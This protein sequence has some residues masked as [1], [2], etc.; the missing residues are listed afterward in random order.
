MRFLRYIAPICFL[1]TFFFA[2][3]TVAQSTANMIQIT[4]PTVRVT[5]PGQSISSAYLQ[6]SNQGASADRLV[7]VS[8]AKAKEVQIHEMKMD[9]DKMMMRQIN[10]LEI[11]AK[12]SVELKPGGYHLM[13]MGLD[14]PIKEGEQIKMTLQFEKAGKVDVVFTSQSMSSM[15]K[16]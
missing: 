1:S 13:L 15:H 12:G 3:F 8:F 9:M 5:A 11:P 2:Q 10:A 6:I 16:H 7:A 4:N 14:S